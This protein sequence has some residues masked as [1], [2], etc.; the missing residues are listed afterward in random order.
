[1]KTL[2][3]ETGKNHY[4]WITYDLRPR[5]NPDFHCRPPDF[6]WRLQDFH[7]RPPDF[8]CRRPDFHCRPPDLHCRLQNFHYKLL[9]FHCWPPD[10]LWRTQICIAD[11]KIS[12]Q[13][14]RLL[15]KTSSISLGTPNLYWI[16]QG[17]HQIFIEEP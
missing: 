17:F 15:L 10:L 14:S 1:M 3:W 16:S 12:L 11:F 9:D 5:E 2:S 4:H 6:H 8:H 7:W 13:T